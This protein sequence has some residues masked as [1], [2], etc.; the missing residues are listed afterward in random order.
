MTAS[1]T[2]PE[3]SREITTPVCPD[4]RRNDTIDA[5]QHEPQTNTV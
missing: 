2:R 5:T 4:S 1:L 3:G